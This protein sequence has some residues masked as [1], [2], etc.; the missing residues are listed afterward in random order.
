MGEGSPREIVRRFQS[1]PI[2]DDVGEAGGPS[3][4]SVGLR[5]LVHS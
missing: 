5:G 1:A 4:A 2:F 3:K